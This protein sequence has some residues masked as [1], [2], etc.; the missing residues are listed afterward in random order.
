MTWPRAEPKQHDDLT[1]TPSPRARTQTTS[2]R[3]PSCHGGRLAPRV[4]ASTRPP[5][6]RP[7]RRPCTRGRTRRPPRWPAG[8]SLQVLQR[9]PIRPS[10]PPSSEDARHLNSPAWSSPSGRPELEQTVLGRLRTSRSTTPTTRW[11]RGGSTR[12]PATRTTRVD[13]AHCWELAN[14]A[15]GDFLAR[16]GWRRACPRRCAKHRSSG[17]GC[18]SSP[19][20]SRMPGCRPRHGPPARTRPAASPMGPRSPSP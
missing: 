2:R 7:H 13:C 18:A 4:G 20:S 19:T 8:R 3:R 12:P 17:P 1:S 16:T 11:S 15:L 10:G 6:G 14:P 5:L 9:R